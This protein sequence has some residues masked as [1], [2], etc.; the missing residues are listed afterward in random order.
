MCL[1]VECSQTLDLSSL[2]LTTTTTNRHGRDFSPLNNQIEKATF[3]SKVGWKY[4]IH[5]VGWNKKYD[6]WLP[7]H[8]LKKF[9]ESAKIA[10]PRRDTGAQQKKGSKKKVEEDEDYDNMVRALAANTCFCL[11]EQSES[12]GYELN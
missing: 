4:F 2:F 6:E 5:Y 3:D 7:Y 12:R 10:K 1:R 8:S 11:P 9:D